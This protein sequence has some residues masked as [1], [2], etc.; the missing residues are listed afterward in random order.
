M[1]EVGCG[2]GAFTT[3]VAAKVGPGGKVYALDTQQKML[4]QLERKLKKPQWSDIENINPVKADAYSIPFKDNF[5]D[6][7][8]MI[9]VL[10]EIPDQIR[11]LKEVKRILKPGGYISVNEFFPDPDY[12]LKSTTI[13]RLKTAGFE[14]D[15]TEGIFWTYTVKGRKPA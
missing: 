1:L 9:T 10:P 4:D 5:F 3:Y 14:I 15:S 12:P 6:L 8:Y 13:S 7:V 2:S 11:A